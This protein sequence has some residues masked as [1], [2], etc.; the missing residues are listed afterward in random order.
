MSASE[1]FTRSA[2]WAELNLTTLRMRNSGRIRR[3]A[4]AFMNSVS[5]AS[6]GGLGGSTALGP[7]LK[8]A[9]SRD[10]WANTT[11]KAP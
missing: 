6:V 7:T 3:S 4:L 1:I 5:W 2:T 10:S 11:A 8:T 9:R